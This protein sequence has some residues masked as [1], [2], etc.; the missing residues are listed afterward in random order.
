MTLGVPRCVPR[1]VVAAASFVFHRSA[2]VPAAHRLSARASSTSAS[3]TPA[4]SSSSTVQH[5]V[6]SSVPGARMLVLHLFACTS[7]Y[8]GSLSPLLIGRFRHRHRHRRFHPARRRSD[9]PIAHDTTLPRRLS[10]TVSS[11]PS[12]RVAAASPPRAAARP[13][14]DFAATAPSR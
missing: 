12:M 6:A 14:V 4:S 2:C 3:S 11:S 13:I 9:H 7:T 1:S 5:G 8:T 10:S